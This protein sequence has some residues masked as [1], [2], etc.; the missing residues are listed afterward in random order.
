MNMPASTPPASVLFNGLARRLVEE[1]TLEAEQ[2]ATA[3]KQAT[4]DKVPLV[5]HLVEQNILD[6]RTIA[7]TA[8]QAFGI[9]L[10]DLDAMDLE[11][12]AH[13]QVDRKLI[14]KHHALPLY[15]RGSRMFVAVS[16]PTNM[17][18]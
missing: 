18:A 17:Q 11:V 15:R 10:L 9:P 14:R 1:G 13:G 16:D 8:S 6:S 3:I 4:R 5:R 12:C 2:A 7:I